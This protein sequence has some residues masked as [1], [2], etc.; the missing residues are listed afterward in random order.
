MKY[1]GT[2]KVRLLS[3]NLCKICESSTH[4]ELIAETGTRYIV[5]CIDLVRDENFPA[6]KPIKMKLIHL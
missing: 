2:K 3:E 1:R 4:I 5:Q 6:F